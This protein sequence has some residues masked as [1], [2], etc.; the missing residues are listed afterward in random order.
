MR[1]FG[2]LCV[3]IREFQETGVKSQICRWVIAIDAR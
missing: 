1:G 3:M 2:E